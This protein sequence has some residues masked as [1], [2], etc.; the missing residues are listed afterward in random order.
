MARPLQFRNNREPMTNDKPLSGCRVLVSRAKKQAGALSSTLKQMGCEVIEIPFIEIRKP[1]SYK[2]LDSALKNLASYDWL[3]LTSVNGVE[4][5][6]ERMAKRKVDKSA[7]AHLKIAAIGPATKAAI[8]K[9][10]LTVT[11]T[12]KEYVAESVVHRCR[13]A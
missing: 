10:G 6:F 1:S 13:R 11:V 5:M 9:H 7:L 8:E 12:P 3:I 2:P 4:A